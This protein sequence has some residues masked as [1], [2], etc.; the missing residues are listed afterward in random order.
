MHPSALSWIC[1][2]V[3]LASPCALIAQHPDTASVT[4]DV[5]YRITYN[6]KVFF[7]DKSAPFRAVLIS[8]DS[9][10]LM[11]VP[12]PGSKYLSIA[13]ITAQ[14]RSIPLNTLSRISIA[15][16]DAIGRGAGKGALIGFAIGAT[17]GAI[18]YASDGFGQ[19]TKAASVV[20]LA[21]GSVG[22]LIGTAIGSARIVIP[23]NG[24]PRPAHIKALNAYRV[25][26]R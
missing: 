6:A 13:A 17:L 25:K 26:E 22:A 5:E 10:E 7:T 24:K 23:I 4:A 1:L 16:Q 2:S 8:A 19:A 12:R 21:F 3:L 20:G 11:A 15:R 18:G 9:T 14:Q